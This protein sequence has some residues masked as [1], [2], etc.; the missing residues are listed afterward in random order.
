MPGHGKR[1]NER[2]Y[3]VER[4][5]RRF[6]SN[7]RMERRRDRDR[8]SD[9]KSYSKSDRKKRRRSLKRFF[10]KVRFVRN[11]R[12]RTAGMLVLSAAVIYL[13]LIGAYR[14]LFL[15]VRELRETGAV[16]ERSVETD[17]VLDVFRISIRLKSGEILFYRERTERRGEND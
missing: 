3:C 13:M 2:K 4:P 5:R 10:K 15:S 11:R 7:G 17:G 8:R 14:D 1:E 9:S 16:L 6:L 12:K